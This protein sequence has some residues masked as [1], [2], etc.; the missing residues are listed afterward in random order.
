MKRKVISKNE[1]M[2]AAQVDEQVQ[3]QVG[4]EIPSVEVHEGFLPLGGE[5]HDMGALVS[6]GKFIIMGLPGAFTP[7]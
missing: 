4:D 2:A 1:L 5:A 7:C 6:S 3:I